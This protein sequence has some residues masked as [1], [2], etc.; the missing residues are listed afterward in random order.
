FLSVFSSNLDEFFM[1]RVSGIKEMLIIEDIGPMPGELTPSEQLEVIR[2]R[3]L[4]LVDEHTR[5]LRDEVIPELESHGVVIAPYATLSK[6]EKRILADYFI[7]NIFLVLT[8]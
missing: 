6:D 1:V 3:V 4:T 8:P 2:K 7:K 5:C